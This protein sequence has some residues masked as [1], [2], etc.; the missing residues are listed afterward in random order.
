MKTT[1]N[2]IYLAFALFAFACFALAPHAR[3]VTPPPVGGYPGENTALGDDALF[4]YN[5]SIDGENTACGHDS[6]Y[7]LTT[8]IY[9]T[10]FGDDTLHF[11]TGG[12]NNT[13]I[14][15]DAMLG[16]STGSMNT[17][18][19]CDALENTSTGGVNIAIGFRAGFAIT[20]GSNNIEI[21][22]TGAP[23]D[24]NTIRIGT[25]GTQT[26]TFIAGIFGVPITSG[27]PLGINSSGQLGV[28]PSS[29]RFK[30]AIQPMD[31]ASEAILAL[32]PVTFHYK[33]ELDPKGELQ[34]GLVAE[35]VAKVNPNLVATD[36]QG[37]PFTVRYE[38][39]NA[40][41]LNEFLKEHRKV[42]SLEKAM[43]NQQK[44]NTAMRAMLNEQ[45]EQIQKVS[46]QVELG[47]AAP[48][49]VANN[50]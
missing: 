21:G 2:I 11:S 47:K 28:R 31:K 46:A 35:E 14:G 4:S 15:W 20:T 1:T 8:G 42:E 39:V 5:T 23:G 48:R 7:S 34:F 29:V 18:I 22:S 6:L 30:E 50:H 3:A 43:A 26:A 49:T 36:E 45:A 27:V 24:T 41:L 25:G 33:K 37:K 13:A 12:N 40:M 32:K 16:N 19:G 44:E 9:N 10:A 38:E 17:G